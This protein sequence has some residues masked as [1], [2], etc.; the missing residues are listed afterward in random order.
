MLQIPS[1]L[2][3]PEQH[4]RVFSTLMYGQWNLEST[5]I[6][7]LP[8]HFVA[9]ILLI[10]FE[11]V[12]NITKDHTCETNISQLPS[13]RPPP[14]LRPPTS[15]PSP[16]SPCFSLL[17]FYNLHH[18]LPPPNFCGGTL[19][20]DPRWLRHWSLKFTVELKI[21]GSLLTNEVHRC[22]PPSVQ[23]KQCSNGRRIHSYCF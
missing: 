19:P 15:H 14:P 22:I 13:P 6:S 12:F 18:P 23:S 8:K 16:L 7:H 11:L 4:T 5:I 9:I 21:Y 1:S 2:L 3:I 20:P 10:C 17:H